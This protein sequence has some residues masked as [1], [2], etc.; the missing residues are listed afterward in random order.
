[1]KLAAN[2][3]SQHLKQTLLPVYIISGDELLLVQETVGQLRTVAAQQGFQERQIFTLDSHFNAETLSSALDNFSLFATRRL[4]ELRLTSASINADVQLILKRYAENAAQDIL[5]LIQAPRLDASVQRSPWFKALDAVGIFVPIWPL[6]RQQLPQWIQQR[7][8][9]KKLKI[10]VA[11]AQLLAEQV[12]GNLLAASQEIEK[13]AL[14][15]P[16]TTI[17]PEFLQQSLFEQTHYDVYELTDALLMQD[18]TRYLKIANRLKQEGTEMTLV[19]W[20]IARE[21]RQCIDFINQL[22]QKIP[23][24]NLLRALPFPQQKRL[25]KYVSH[26]RDT[27]A[28]SNTLGYLTNIDQ[29][30]KGV[31]KG[32]PWLA[33]NN[34][35]L[36]FK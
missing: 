15:A 9:Q 7:C 13:L 11:A 1:M 24:E 14:L 27:A 5:L 3:F 2:Q 26:H 30:T 19:L 34:L 25:K 17:D 32:E 18:L 10:T 20:A 28:L 12:E 6:E 4:I 36:S 35:V 23:L 8:Q 22:Q 29:M 31:K 33:L 16:T 21:I